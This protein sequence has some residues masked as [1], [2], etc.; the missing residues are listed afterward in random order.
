M[1][2]Q[3]IRLATT[4][5]DHPPVTARPGRRWPQTQARRTMC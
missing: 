5:C 3:P 4:Q 2:I 1:A